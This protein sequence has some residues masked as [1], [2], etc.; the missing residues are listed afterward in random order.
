[1]RLDLRSVPFYY[2]NTPARADRR[3]HMESRLRGFI[4]ERIEGVAPTGAGD[5]RLAL[6]AVGHARVVD[7]A[8][9]CMA[10]A[11]EP[12][13]LLED[14]VE[15]S[16]APT[17]AM[18]I[19]VPACA[20]AVHVG[21]SDCGCLPDV[22]SN[23]PNLLRWRSE[24]HPHVFR[25]YNM[26]S[27]HAVLFLSYRYCVAYSRAMME[28][29]V[30]TQSVPTVWDT[31]S[32]RL[33][34]SHEVYALARPLL[35]QLGTL[36][37]QEEA[38]RID[39]SADV[40]GLDRSDRFPGRVYHTVPISS[41]L[42]S[43][44]SP[45]PTIV[46]RCAAAEDVERLAGFET[47]AAALVVCL[48]KTELDRGLYDCAKAALPFAKIVLSDGRRPVETL[49]D[50][51]RVNPHNTYRFLFAAQPAD[52]CSPSIRGRLRPSAVGEHPRGAADG[53]PMLLGGDLDS[54][55]EFA[56]APERYRGR[57]LVYSLAAE[58]D[59]V[60]DDDDVKDARA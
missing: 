43:P 24:V 50:V 58:D 28:A 39:W 22:N 51:L 54:L 41:G 40:A 52:A 12:F 48:K 19:E 59:A 29:C 16:E 34:A 21:I 36:G 1:M 53:H 32:N 17:E 18:P 37:G 30:L 35:Y 10:G 14:D 3:A 45:T 20:D 9:R 60:A 23:G 11:F 13:V 2:R 15:W 47:A 25:V 56:S 8:V 4:H 26:L 57:D 46:T 44:M 27:A 6:G 42:S 55:L 38:T 33:A 49:C 5:S 7:Y 31:I